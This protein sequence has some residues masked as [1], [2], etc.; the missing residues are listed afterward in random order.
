LYSVIPQKKRDTSNAIMS[1]MP[2]E[3]MF[4]NPA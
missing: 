2:S 1:L 4:S 3:E